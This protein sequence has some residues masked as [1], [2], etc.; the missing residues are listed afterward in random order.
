MKSLMKWIGLLAVVLCTMLSQ[1]TAWATKYEASQACTDS[2]PT[3]SECT[4]CY[5]GYEE[6]TALTGFTP[7]VPRCTTWHATDTS[8]DPWCCHDDFA[9]ANAVKYPSAPTSFSGLCGSGTPTA[10]PQPVT[11]K[12]TGQATKK[13][14]TCGSYLPS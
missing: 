3:P 12:C 11:D 4:G 2:V 5:P 1:N 13:G 6:R 10:L 9:C 8:K 14:G 7:R